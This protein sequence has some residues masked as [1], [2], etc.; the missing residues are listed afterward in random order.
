MKQNNKDKISTTMLNCHQIN[1]KNRSVKIWHILKSIWQII[2][3]GENAQS[4]KISSG[5]K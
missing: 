1:E 3:F 2:I 5:E 4:R